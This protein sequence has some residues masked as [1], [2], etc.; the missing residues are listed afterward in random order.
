[1]KIA[2]ST[3][4]NSGLTRKEAEELGITIIPTPVI[5]DG[6]IYLEDIS[7][8]QEFFY[9]KLTGNSQISTSQPSP[10]SLMEYWDKLLEDY[11]KVIYI[12]I[13]SGLAA[14]F[15]T[16]YQLTQTEEKY[17]GKVFAIDNHRVSVT[18]KQSLLDVLKMVKEGKSAEVIVQWLNDTA[19]KSSIYIMVDT[20]TYLKK[21][22][23]LNPAVAFVGNLLKIKPVLQNHGQKFD[24]FTKARKISD[25]KTAMIT[26][27]KKDLETEFKDEYK[28]GKMTLQ[29]AH[30]KNL[31]AALKF[32]AEIEEAFPNVEF[33]FVDSLSLSV[34]CHIGPGALAVACSIK[35]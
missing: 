33:T 11:D 35:Y 26:A 25:A 2:I 31:E 34:S 1:M 18:Q 13:S 17:K 8:T 32:K 4:G 24:Q 15:D 30:T 20:L 19:M 9:E 21:G 3:D 23:R 10:D 16:A 22:G 12:P 27:I 5:I 7:L 28:V 6:E 29:V 14:A